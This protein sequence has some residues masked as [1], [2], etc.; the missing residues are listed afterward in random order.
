MHFPICAL[1]IQYYTVN[2]YTIILI[3]VCHWY[4]FTIFGIYNYVKI[5]LIL[6]P[7]TNLINKGIGHYPQL[8]LKSMKI[9]C[10]SKI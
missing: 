4:I 7:I 10:I 1:N 5:N 8:T 2:L 6:R 9:K 3:H